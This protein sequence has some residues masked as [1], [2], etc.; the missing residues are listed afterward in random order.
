MKS[1]TTW[2][3]IRSHRRTLRQI[4]NLRVKTVFDFVQHDVLNDNQLVTSVGVE[5]EAGDLIEEELD[6]AAAIVRVVEISLLERGGE[7]RELASEL[8]LQPIVLFLP[9]IHVPGDRLH[10]LL[11]AQTLLGVLGGVAGYALPD[12]PIPP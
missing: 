3:S 7:M 10:D 5:T 12:L 2:W 9:L 11:F 6:S 8:C 1:A 4:N